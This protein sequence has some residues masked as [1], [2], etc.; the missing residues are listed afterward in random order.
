[1]ILWITALHCTILSGYFLWDFLHHFFHEERCTV[2]AYMNNLFDTIFHFW[3]LQFL[4]LCTAFICISNILNKQHYWDKPVST[5]WLNN[6]SDASSG[7]AWANFWLAILRINWIP[8][9]YQ[10]IQCHTTYLPNYMSQYP[11]TQ[12]HR[13]MIA[14]YQTT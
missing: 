9:I 13:V 3:A 5:G 11:S 6:G 14:T 12:L 2:A 7:E 10:I 4:T 1:M 8:C